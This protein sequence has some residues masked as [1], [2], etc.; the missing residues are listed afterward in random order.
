MKP[1]TKRIC[2]VI[3]E[4]TPLRVEEAIAG[5]EQNADLLELRLDYLSGKDLT[6]RNLSGWIQKTNR[7]VILTLR[8]TANGWKFPGSEEDQISILRTLLH[9]GA[10]YIDL[11]IES[12]EGFL[13]NNLDPLRGGSCRLI[14]SYHNFQDTPPDLTSVYERLREVH[15][16]IVKIATFGLHFEDNLR[17]LDLARAASR[18]GQPI[19][20]L[21]MGELGIYSRVAGLALGSLWTYGSVEAGMESAPGQL[22]TAELRDLYGV[23]G[24]QQDT[25]IYGVV[26]YPLDHSLSPHIHNPAFSAMGINARYL[27]FPVKDMGDFGPHLKRFDGFSVTIPHKI[28][29]LRYVDDIDETV[30][31]VGAANTVAKRDGKL[32]AYNTD[33]TGVEK[34]LEQ[35]FHSGIHS[36]IL[37][38]TGGAARAAAWVLA[39]HECNVTVLARDTDKARAFAR[40]FGFSH[41][42]LKHAFRYRGDLLIN[43]T[44][45]GMSPKIDESPVPEDAL[46]YRHVFDMVYNPLE[47]LLLR[48]ARKKSSVIAGLEMFVAQAARQFE[49]WTGSEPPVGL[50]RQIVVAHLTPR[51]GDS[52]PRPT[53]RNQDKATHGGKLESSH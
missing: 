43:A 12:V 29:V 49:L 1:S 27:P 36:V 11:E 28:N 19:V 33:V 50:M 52:L 9:V 38:G 23:N 7:P 26:G 6:A 18:H 20:L 8:R 35:A 22:T 14:V 30:K 40:E 34:A 25:R 51:I 45:T 47:T 4:A 16:D 53:D 42:A 24:I 13:N 5:S 10:A 48:N 46:D 41:D 44:S 17:M 32:V 15:A 21:V 3:R 2:V 39:K 37:L 31:Q